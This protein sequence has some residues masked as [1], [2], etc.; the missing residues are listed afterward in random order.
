MVKILM[1]KDGYRGEG[2]GIHRNWMPTALIS[3]SV[4]RVQTMFQKGVWFFYKCS[5]LV[6][7]LSQ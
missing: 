3:I 7:G 1:E 2:E 5:R 4:I 6:S